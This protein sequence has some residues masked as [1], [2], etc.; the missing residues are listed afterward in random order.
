MEFVVLS[1][2]PPTLTKLL[3][4][5]DKRHSPSNQQSYLPSHFLFL[6]FYFPL[7]TTLTTTTFLSSL[8]SILF[9]PTSFV[10]TQEGKPS[11]SLLNQTLCF[12]IHILFSTATLL[13]LTPVLCPLSSIF[14][15][16]EQ[17]LKTSFEQSPPPT[18]DTSTSI[19]IRL[20]GWAHLESSPPHDA[21]A[22]SQYF[23]SSQYV[24][25]P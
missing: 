3:L 10:P 1:C 24:Q 23:T 7:P 14:P 5:L 9:F 20:V 21:I 18:S 22:P 19:S 17:C 11:T 16:V 25:P 12:C 15:W 13:G 4:M 2:W 8:W 6:F